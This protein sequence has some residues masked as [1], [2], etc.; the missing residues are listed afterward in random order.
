MLARVVLWQL[1]FQ[2]IHGEVVVAVAASIPGAVNVG[3]RVP[4][5][6]GG[7]GNGFRV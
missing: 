3:L 7:Y 1:V 5:C 6:K 4:V 2:L